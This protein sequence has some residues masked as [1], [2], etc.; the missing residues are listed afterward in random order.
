MDLQSFRPDRD[1]FLHWNKFCPLNRKESS[2]K[3]TLIKKQR[4]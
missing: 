3:T 2:L 1:H 4:T